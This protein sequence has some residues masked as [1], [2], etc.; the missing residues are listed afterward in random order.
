MASARSRSTRITP[1]K[2]RLHGELCHRA[3]TSAMINGSQIGDTISPTTSTPVVGSGDGGIYTTVSEMHRFWEA[4]LAGCIV[5]SRHVQ[6]MW[7]PR[8]DVPTEGRRYGRASG[9]P[10]PDQASCSRIRRRRLLPQHVHS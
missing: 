2:S 4:L 6:M 9:W 8:G 5:D 3:T 7:E 1:E 10:K